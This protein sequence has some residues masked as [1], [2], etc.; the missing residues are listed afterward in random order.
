[1]E[2]NKMRIIEDICTDSDIVVE[3]TPD[4][5]DYLRITVKRSYLHFCI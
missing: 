1:M 4:E 2:S 5:K 3:R